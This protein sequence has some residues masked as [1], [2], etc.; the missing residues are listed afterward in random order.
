LWGAGEALRERI[1]CRV[2]PASRRNRER[3]LAQLR[4]QLGE[5]EFARL[6]GEGTTWPLEQVVAEALHA[7]L[8][9]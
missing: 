6:A 1:G 3:T 8:E 5:V 4:V 2:A 7:G 9:K